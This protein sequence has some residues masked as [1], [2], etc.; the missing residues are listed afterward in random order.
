MCL[1]WEER[2]DLGPA[3]DMQGRER[4]IQKARR[5]ANYKMDK[6]L[7]EW[8]TKDAHQ[9]DMPGI[10]GCGGCVLCC[11]LITPPSVLSGQVTH[12]YLIIK[13]TNKKTM[14][15]VS[16]LCFRRELWNSFKYLRTKIT[17]Y[18]VQTNE[19]FDLFCVYVVPSVC[20][21]MCFK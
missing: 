17:W 20:T 21:C 7:T 15:L 1:L 13:K 18:G 16:I 6:L 12:T 10:N 2:S 4:F 19:A 9:A 11:G 8:K 3:F 5:Q 14:H